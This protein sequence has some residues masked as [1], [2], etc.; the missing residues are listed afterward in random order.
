MEEQAEA[1]AAADIS[2]YLHQIGG[3]FIGVIAWCIVYSFNA[4]LS[5]DVCRSIF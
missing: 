4:G 5:T 2:E 1:A 3:I